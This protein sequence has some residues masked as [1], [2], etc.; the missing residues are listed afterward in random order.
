VGKHCGAVSVGKQWA[1]TEVLHQRGKQWASTEVLHQCGKQW[2]STEVL[3]Q[4][5][6]HCRAVSVGFLAPCGHAD[7]AAILSARGRPST[8]AGF[9]AG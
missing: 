1:S 5:G 9:E 2:A 7:V 8:G 3:Y 6:K 4:C